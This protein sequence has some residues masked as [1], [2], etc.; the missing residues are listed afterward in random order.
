MKKLIFFQNFF[1]YLVFHFLALNKTG[2]KPPKYAEGQK[3]TNVFAFDLEESLGYYTESQWNAYVSRK[4]FDCKTNSKVKTCGNDPSNGIYVYDSEPVGETICAPMSKSL[5]GELGDLTSGSHDITQAK[6]VILGSVFL[7][8]IISVTILFLSSCF[9]GCIIWMLIWVF[10]LTLALG[11]A[12]SFFLLY[13]SVSFAAS[14]SEAEMMQVLSFL[15]PERAAQVKEL[16][17]KKH[18]LVISGVGFTLLFLASVITVCCKA[19]NIR[20]STQVIH[21]SASFLSKNWG[22][23]I[24]LL[25]CFTFQLATIGFCAFGLLAI[26]TGGK[27]KGNPDGWPFHRYS[28]DLKRWAMAGFW[29]FCSYWVIVFWNNLCDFTVGGQTVN[30]EFEIPNT[31]IFK[32]FCQSI[33]YHSGSVA[34]G[35]LALNPVALINMVCI[36]KKELPACLEVDDDAFIIVYLSKLN[37][38][39]GGR[40][41]YYLR[42]Q[43]GEKV[44]DSDVVIVIY[45]IIARF[46]IA[47][48]ST[49]ICYHV[50]AHVAPYNDDVRNPMVPALVRKK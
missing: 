14:G 44:D 25:I 6:W 13:L 45:S 39:P 21:R 20:T 29:I 38:C 36:C 22:S 41:G 10:I 1:I 37:F 18:Y 32:T 11:A 23:Y 17:K 9:A 49:L 2:Q 24:I 35:S 26:H 28:Y 47:I 50:L 48:L 3:P 30:N 8:L 33:F 7:T 42:K 16:T 5:G 15:S 12:A 34:L 31:G 27:E 19:A 43:A 46:S 4:T 40:L